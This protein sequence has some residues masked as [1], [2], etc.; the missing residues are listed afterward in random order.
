MEDALRAAAARIGL[1]SGRSAAR[2]EPVGLHAA[3]G[4]PCPAVAVDGSH[5]VLHDNGRLWVVAYR[6]AAVPSAG[7]LPTV[8]P[9][10]A[11]AASDEAAAI[12]ALAWGDGAPERVRTAESFAEALCAAAECR[13]ALAAMQ[14]ADPP[15]LPTRGA[16]PLLLV[17]GALHG[18]APPADRL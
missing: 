11:V 1:D 16:R 14:P 10:V 8:Q 4:T 13:A 15:A 18:L 12:V 2:R 5:A 7:R 17:D 6:A 3:S 9:E